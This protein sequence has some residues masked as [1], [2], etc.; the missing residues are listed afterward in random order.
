MTSYLR[1]LPV[2]A[3]QLLLAHHLLYWIGSPRSVACGTPTPE[4]GDNGRADGLAAFCPRTYPYMHQERTTEA[5]VRS[6]MT[7]SVLSGRGLVWFPLEESGRN[8]KLSRPW[9]GPYWVTNRQDPN[10]T[11]VRV[12]FPAISS[13]IMHSW[14]CVSLV[15]HEE[16]GAGPPSTM[17]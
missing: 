17:G 1:I 13:C 10:L 16:E 5:P 11:V 8:Q 9:H 3:R 4:K 14:V 6:N 2:L 12:C 7:G 15:W